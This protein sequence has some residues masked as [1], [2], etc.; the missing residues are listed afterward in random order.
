MSGR[1]R[2]AASRGPGIHDPYRTARSR[3]TSEGRAKMIPGEEEMGKRV[4]SRSPASVPGYDRA[5][6]GIHNLQRAEVIADPRVYWNAIA[7]LPP[8]FYEEVGGVWVCSGYSE[9]AE[10]LTNGRAFSSARHHAPGELQQRG[11]EHFL[12]TAEMLS[13]QFLFSDPPEHTRIRDALRGQFTR[14]SV[15]RHD[16]AMRDM[17]AELLRSLPDHGTVD[18][19]ADF[20]EQLPTRLMTYLLGMDGRAEELTRWA[21][22]YERLLSSMSTFPSRTDIEI[23]SVIDEALAGLRQMTAERLATPGDD[24]LSTLATALRGD[25]GPRSVSSGSPPQELLQ[26]VAANAMVLIAGGY[27]TLTHLVSTGLLLL[28]ERPEQL[29][30]LRA[31]PS[32]IDSAV[33]EVMRIDGS[34]QYVGRHVV[35]DVEIGGVPLKAGASVIVLLGAANLDPRK[36]RDP[37]VFD[38]GRREGRHLG[39]GAGP[40]YCLG[41]P[42][43]ERLA[44]LAIQGFIEKYQEFT[45]SDGPT[46]AVQWGRHGNTRSRAH[47]GMTVQRGAGEDAPGIEPPDRAQDVLPEPKTVTELERHQLV[48]EWNETGARAGTSALVCWHV[49]F[50]ERARLTPDAIAV[51][52]QG[53]PY[54]YARIDALANG[55]AHRLR[56]LGVEPE[57]VVAITMRR[58][59]DLVVALLAVAKAGGAFL[60]ADAACPA[61]RLKTMLDQAHVRVVLTDDGTADRVEGLDV[62]TA[63]TLLDTATP[64][65][66]P[67]ITGVLPGNTA[68]VVFTSGTTGQPKAIVNSHESLANLHIAQRRVF[69]VRPQDRVLQFLSLNF[70]GCISEIVLALLCGATLVLAST[71]ALMPG[72]S[73]ARLLRER[74]VTIAIMT[75]SVWAV[76]PSPD[77]PDLRIA[78]F[79]GE[80]LRGDLV[81]RW[82]MRGRRL[83]NLYGP[84]EAAIWSTWHECSEE[85]DAPP[86]GRPVLG[87]RVYVLDDDRRLLPVGCPG[88]LYI[89][90]VGVGR[91]LGRP[92][93]MADSFVP[94]TF[95]DEPGRLLYR[96]GDLCVWRADGV[97][98]YV[99]RRD[100]Q[101]KIRGQRVELDEVERVLEGAPGVSACLVAERDG[102]LTA[103]VVPSSPGSWREAEV[104]TYLSAH[105]HTGMVPATFTLADRLPITRNGK[106]G[107]DGPEPVQAQA[108]EPGG[109]GPAAP[110]PRAISRPAEDRTQGADDPSYVTWELAR[111]FSSCLGL[112]QAAVKLDT[113]FFSAGGDSLAIAEFMVTAEERFDVEI[114]VE[115]LLTDPT[116]AG[117][118]RLVGQREEAR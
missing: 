69:R 61:E 22:A 83:L 45:P 12:P 112:P 2:P 111:L 47:A 76:I 38:I 30:R 35:R 107:H 16:P 3:E 39:F 25:F 99:G 70:D 28:T 58:S 68:Y 5:R 13:A 75:P 65:A 72:P 106:A 44:G 53:V 48:T 11:M 90:G 94:D 62:P 91:Y 87:K 59:V 88:E 24:L 33:D 93:R 42:F 71:E 104:R 23:V 18:V 95:T 82:R 100:R 63:V 51:E 17:V 60:L 52:D 114:R 92:D 8:I 27:Q 56:A 85:D 20:A 40:H 109:D 43:A 110:S 6:H 97:L 49:L 116:L 1:L 55:N 21:D 31:E 73:L 37:L 79:A 10:I 102:R 26:L 41:A 101:V 15:R 74:R 96:T 81:R 50:E 36:F 29:Q 32:L 77:L 78:A 46:G 54:S 34:S 67:P 80:R 118:V 66:E 84:A 105:L 7:E 57:S 86:I 89:G 98:E 9:A 103:L 115:E 14:A 4:V 117:L 108:I 64:A 19:V 113:D